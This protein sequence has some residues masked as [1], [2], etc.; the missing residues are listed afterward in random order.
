MQ[1]VC[2]KLFSKKKF[3]RCFFWRIV[4]LCL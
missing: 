1:T 4:W 3:G 2:Q